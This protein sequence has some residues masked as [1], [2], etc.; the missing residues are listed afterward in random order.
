MSA[1]RFARATLA[2]LGLLVF[3]LWLPVAAV[4]YVPGWHQASCDWHM[5]CDYYG[6]EKALLRID[7]LREFM[8]HR[9][10]LPALYWTEKET[11]HLT[12]V[13]GMLDRSA[14]IALLGAAIFF[15]GTAGDRA[16]AAR[17]AMLVAAACVIIL[18]FFTTFWREI[19]HP[20]LFSNT[21][22]KNTPADTSYWVMPRLYF[23]YTTGLVI[24]VATLTCAALRYQ[25]IWQLRRGGRPAQ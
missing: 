12:E 19:F 16:R 8:Q 7:E 6:R 5:R 20:L 25:A 18:P 23:Q 3:A 4:T 22:W 11:A 17:R 24:G 13:R 10:E 21:L 14:L 9:G 15:H 2:L 1:M